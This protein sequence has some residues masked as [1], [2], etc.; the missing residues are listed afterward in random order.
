MISK[1]VEEQLG[2]IGKVTR[3]SGEDPVSNAISFAQFK[4]KS[5]DFGWGFDEPGHGLSFAST[6]T[7]ELAIA[8]SPFSHLGKHAPLIWFQ[9]GEPNEDIY[10][11]LASKRTAKR[12]VQSCFYDW[13]IQC[14]FFQDTGHH[15]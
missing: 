12:T 8:A 14:Y 11:F 9:D 13:N 5:T 7:P 15:R 3:I 4:D 2:E 6:T 1:N 10:K